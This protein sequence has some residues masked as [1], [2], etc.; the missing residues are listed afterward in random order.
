M[1]GK[2]HGERSQ[3]AKHDAEGGSE[4]GAEARGDLER[5]ALSEFAD[6]PPELGPPRRKL[7]ADAVVP[8]GGGVSTASGCA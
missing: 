1:T 2:Q 5:R 6:C 7:Q 4:E 8:V 3:R